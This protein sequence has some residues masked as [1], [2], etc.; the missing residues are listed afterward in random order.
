MEP[1]ILVM[2]EPSAGLDP[3]ARRQMIALVASFGHTALIATHDLDMAQMLCPRT[4]IMLAGQVAA[5]GPTKQLLGD[6]A[7]LERCGL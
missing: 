2:D 5:D 6:S 3:R 1:S 7:L 4:V